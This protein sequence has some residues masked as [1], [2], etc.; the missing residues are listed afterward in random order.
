ML[1]NIDTCRKAFEEWAFGDLGLEQD[2]IPQLNEDG[3]YD[4]VGTQ[5]AW[6]AWLHLSEEN[7]QLREV[8]SVLMHQRKEAVS[9]LRRCQNAVSWL[10][11]LRQPR[12]EHLEQFTKEGHKLITDTLIKLWPTKQ[13]QE[14][15]KREGE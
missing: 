6:R 9:T 5:G 1:N 15:F 3:K 13:T 12:D 14:A 8:L 11:D 7:E 10:A 2:E 4:Y